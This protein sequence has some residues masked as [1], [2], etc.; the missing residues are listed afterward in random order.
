MKALKLGT[1]V[2][3]SISEVKGMLTHL[4]ISIGGNKEYIFQ[5]SAL[6]PK[7][8][9]PVK[10]IFMQESRI[11]DG[12]FVEIEVPEHLFGKKAND[13]ATLFKGRI[14]TLIYHINGCWH[15]EL[16][17]KGLNEDNNTFETCEFDL[18][19]LECKHIPEMT[20][21]EY[22]KSKAETPSPED[23]INRDR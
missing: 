18:R 17:P 13:K 11:E 19:R 2:T 21:E 7:D 6:N 12:E 8:G 9:K 22:E 16:K 23:H 5:P 15:A 3:D 4:M 10:Q 1:I 14:V 20:D